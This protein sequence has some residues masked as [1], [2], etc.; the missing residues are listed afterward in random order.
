MGRITLHV[1]DGHQH[2]IPV[3]LQLVNVSSTLQSITNKSQKKVELPETK[4][5]QMEWWKGNQLNPIKI[6]VYT[7]CVL[8][9]FNS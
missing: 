8:T 4:Q 1:S 3:K 2:Q 9:Q 6:Y 7:Y 5:F